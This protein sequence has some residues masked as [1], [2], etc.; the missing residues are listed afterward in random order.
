MDC[1]EETKDDF[2]NEVLTLRTENDQLKQEI[3]R[4]KQESKQLHGFQDRF[5]DQNKEIERLKLEMEEIKSEKMNLAENMLMGG[6]SD[7]FKPVANPLQAALINYLADSGVVKTKRVE[8]I[9]KSVDRG[10][11]APASPYVDRAQQ[12]VCNTTISAPHM[13]ALQIEVLKDTLFEAKSALDI[14]TGSGIVALYMAK[15]MPEGSKV[16]ALDHIQQ[17]LDFAKANIAKNNKEYIDNGNI[18]FVLGDGRHGLPD[19]APYDVIFVGG[20]VDTI[21]HDLIDQLAPGGSMVIP[22]GPGT[23][24]LTAVHKTKDGKILTKG[25]MS[26]MFGKL[27]SVEEQMPGKKPQQVQPTN[28]TAI[29]EETG[30]PNWESEDDL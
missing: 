23:Q 28:H 22:I 17:I 8:T 12:I 25:M 10:D 6:S 13:H 24:T 15:I 1:L 30:M 2:F 29:E 26:V 5:D 14:G 7:R 11:F 21:P 4:L 9:L 19:H 16:Y 3:E 18:E 20:A 27:Q